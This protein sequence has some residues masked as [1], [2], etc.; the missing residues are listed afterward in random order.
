MAALGPIML[1]SRSRLQTAVA[2]SFI[3]KC[4]S[5]SCIPHGDHNPSCQ[6]GTCCFSSVLFPLGI[7]ELSQQQEVAFLLACTH[8]AFTVLGLHCIQQWSYLLNVF[9]PFEHTW[10]PNLP[11]IWPRLGPAAL[12]FPYRLIGEVEVVLL[13]PPIWVDWFE[14]YVTFDLLHPARDTASGA[15]GERDLDALQM[16]AAGV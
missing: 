14:I 3:A 16:C 5:Y 13:G 1:A 8:A 10:P 4:H 9:L 6:R 12:T 15:S 11:F 7:S 2:W